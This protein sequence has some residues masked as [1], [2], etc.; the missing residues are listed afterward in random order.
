[1]P[2]PKRA[3]ANDR[4]IT[5]LPDVDPTELRLGIFGSFNAWPS[6]DQELIRLVFR[7]AARMHELTVEHQVAYPTNL[8]LA[9]NALPPPYVPPTSVEK[10]VM[11]TGT[12]PAMTACR[13]GILSIMTARYAK[14]KCTNAQNPSA[15]HSEL[16]RASSMLLAA[17][18]EACQE[19]A[20]FSHLKEMPYVKEHRLADDPTPLTMEKMNKVTEKIRRALD[21]RKLAPTPKPLA[22]TT[23]KLVCF[24][25]KNAASVSKATS[26]PKGFRGGGDRRGARDPSTIQCNMCAQ[27]GHGWLTKTQN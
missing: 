6:G 5:L 8:N 10:D 3:A 1:M 9:P 4:S 19:D 23:A 16:Q 11:Y 22:S 2:P 13:E 18:L 25:T 24:E 26:A 20:R 27:L 7:I 12:E 14:D 21:D 17:L 15:Q